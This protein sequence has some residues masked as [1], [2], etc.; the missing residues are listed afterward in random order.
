[1]ESQPIK[2]PGRRVEFSK[3]EGKEHYEATFELKNESEME[4]AYKIRKH[5]TIKYIITPYIETIKPGESR[6]VNCKIDNYLI[7]F[8]FR[9]YN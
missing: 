4:V 7:M 5:S 2:L 9:E 3:P 1:M 6:I 8:V